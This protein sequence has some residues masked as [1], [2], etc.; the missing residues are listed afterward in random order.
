MR[1]RTWNTT[2]HIQKHPKKVRETPASGCA[3]TQGNPFVVR[4]FLVKTPEKNNRKPVAHACT[5]E[6]PFGVTWTLVTCTNILYYYYSK[7][8]KKCEK[9]QRMRTRALLVRAAY[10][11]VTSGS[12]TTSMWL[13]S[14]IYTTN[15]AWS[16]F[17]SL[18]WIQPLPV[19]KTLIANRAPIGG[20]ANG[21]KGE[22]M[23]NNA[24]MIISSQM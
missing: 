8:I 22:N 7:K 16:T 6:N 11:D 19:Q 14:N 20:S 18:K 4:S 23:C 9:N 13:C 12:S 15:I 3:C 17:Q 24:I 2:Q 1:T 21:H 5:Q 10:G